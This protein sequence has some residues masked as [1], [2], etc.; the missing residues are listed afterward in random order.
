MVRMEGM[1]AR[2]A[3]Q[4]P[5]RRRITDRRWAVL[6]VIVAFTLVAVGSCAALL[7]TVE[8]PTR[9]QLAVAVLLIGYMTLAWLY[10]LPFTEKTKLHLDTTV[11]MGAI[12]HFPAGIAMLI[13]G[14][15]TLLGQMLR[16][17]PSDQAVF[18]SAQTMLQA[19]AGAGVLAATGW[20]AQ[21]S[22]AGRPTQVL[23]IVA[24]GAAMF[25]LSL[26]AVATIVGLQ[27]GSP[28]RRVVARMIEGMTAVDDLAQVA[29]ICLGVIAAALAATAPWTLVL[30]LVPAAAIFWV[31]QHNVL[32]RQRLAA[33]LYE[34]EQNL[35]EAERIAQLGWWEWQLASEDHRWS[36]GIYRIIGLQPQAV[37]PSFQAFVQRVHPD[38]RSALD[39]AVQQALR[40]GTSFDI[41]FRLLRADGSQCSVQTHGVVICDAMG[42]PVRMVGIVHDITERKV[43]EARLLQQGASL[44]LTS[45]ELEV[46]K[47]LARGNANKEIATELGISEQTVKNH[48]TSILRKL[49]VNDRNQA[50][51][52]ALSYGWID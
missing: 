20:D 9:A 22:F 3:T 47:Y 33:T 44:A 41:E 26:L 29:Q 51:V 23:A 14:L 19:A 46:L 45:R 39:G 6:V 24:A 8:M 52:Y 17:Q 12:L 21:Q 2:Q 32:L 27:T 28:V 18:N 31:L 10:P 25:I 50:V 36:D 13:V 49:Q 43:L 11:T 42:Q 16:R 1:H 30:L 38:D 15:G 7:Q 37:I 40:A 4:T 34:R 35:A 48:V 5:W